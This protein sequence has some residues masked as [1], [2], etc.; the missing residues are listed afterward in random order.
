[1]L[2][3]A[4]ALC[5]FLI[6]FLKIIACSFLQCRAWETSPN[7][8]VRKQEGNWAFT[9]FEHVHLFFLQSFLVWF[10]SCT[11]WQLL[12]LS[13]FYSP[14][15]PS[16]CAEMSSFEPQARSGDREEAGG[17]GEEGAWWRQETAEQVMGSQLVL[18][19]LQEERRRKN[20][21]TNQTEKPH[22]LVYPSF[23][24]LT[25]TPSVFVWGVHYKIRVLPGPAPQTYQE[26]RSM[27]PSA[28]LPSLT[29]VYGKQE[30]TPHYEMLKK[31]FF[32]V[33]QP[34]TTFFFS[35]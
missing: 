21:P 31:L 3:D 1:M 17:G 12:A 5:N 28:G 34:L 6:I 27:W 32:L 4:L 23:P 2:R 8:A 35:I 10:Q 29:A 7:K 22:C 24:S 11:E 19:P 18:P 26:D 9:R 15:F 33:L 16:I 25:A 30:T 20:K 14:C 13:A